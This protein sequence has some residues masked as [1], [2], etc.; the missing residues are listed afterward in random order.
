MSVETAVSGLI[1]DVDQLNR[2]YSQLFDVPD[3]VQ[4]LIRLLA[5][6]KARL[7]LSSRLLAKTSLEESSND[8]D[9]LTGKAFNRFR[10]H[11]LDLELFLDPEQ[12][13]HRSG[14]GAQNQHSVRWD[15]F[16]HGDTQDFCFHFKEYIFQLD[17]DCSTLITFLNASVYGLHQV[18]SIILIII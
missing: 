7:T 14:V 16:E 13:L 9:I 5:D 15:S 12:W 2:L 8:N 6:S 17:S 10:S 3:E 4:E 1:T 18:N 11:L